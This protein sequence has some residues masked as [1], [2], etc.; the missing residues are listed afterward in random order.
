MV[1]LLWKA[2]WKF[3]KRLN[4]ELPYD[5]REMKTNLRSETCTQGAPG[6]LGWLSVQPQLRSWS[7]SSQV[8][9]ASGSL[10]TAQSPLW[11]LC[12][13]L[14]VP[15]PN[16]CSLSKINKHFKKEQKNLYTNVCNSI[17]LSRL[18]AQRGA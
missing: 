2:V 5:P 12:P 10:L 18:H 4:T 17:F 15:L 1:W 13:L 14:S 8:Q 3:L 6:W 11:I 16:L 7:C 9:A